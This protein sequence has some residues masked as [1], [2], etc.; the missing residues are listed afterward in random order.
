MIEILGSQGRYEEALNILASDNL[1][2]QSRIVRGDSTFIG[3]KISCLLDAGNK[4]DDA[5]SYAQSLL[6]VPDDEDGRKGLLE[7]DDWKVWD[8]LCQATLHSE[9]T[10]LVHINLN[11]D[12]VKLTIGG[13][14]RVVNEALKLVDQFIE[15]APKSRN[16]SL[17][18]LDIISCGVEK[19]DISGDDKLSAC[20]QYIDQHIHKL[21][22]FQDIRKLWG[23]D[24]N[25]MEKM[26]EY[27]RAHKE[28]TKVSPS[29]RS[30]DPS[31]KTNI[32]I[33]SGP[34]NQCFEAR[35]L[36]VY[37]RPRKY[38]KKNNR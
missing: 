33:D 14:S 29:V 28:G 22:A 27:I 11:K 16:A 37:L 25:G 3:L 4:W 38:A 8:L 6:T 35:V 10:G 5:F 9:K 15:F 17:A 20:Q 34:R 30:K 21:Y 32:P 7:L 2:M 31:I 1:G 18:R 13:P 19:R 23:Q 24:K 12:L 26:L 36:L